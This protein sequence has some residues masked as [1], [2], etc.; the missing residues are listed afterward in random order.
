MGRTYVKQ[1]QFYLNA[2][3]AE[4]KAN[5]EQI[6]EWAAQLTDLDFEKNG[7]SIDEFNA[8]RFLEKNECAETIVEMR[9]SLQMHGLNFNKRLAFIDFLVYYYKRNVR[10][11]LERPQG[12]NEK[13][14]RAQLALEKVNE[15]IEK[16][17]DEKKALEKKAAAG[18]VKAMGAKNQLAQLLAS[19][20]LELNRAVVSAQAAVRMAKKD[21]SNSPQGQLWWV[22]RDLKEAEKY[23]PSNKRRN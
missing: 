2:Y 3:F 12:T 9:E 18:G 19:D 11:L 17:E 22:E 4:D 7:K 15:E 1:G 20:P 23:R 8:H 13:L 5:A 6:W 16:I 21:K 14:E 10:D